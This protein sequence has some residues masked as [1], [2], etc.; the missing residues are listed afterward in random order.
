MAA[1]R[2]SGEIRG[3]LINDIAEVGGTGERMTQP[4]NEEGDMRTGVRPK[5]GRFQRKEGERAKA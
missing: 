2:R 4:G 1:K 3:K 5:E